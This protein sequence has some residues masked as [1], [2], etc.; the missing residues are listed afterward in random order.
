VDNINLLDALRYGVIGLSAIL[1]ILA[2][3]LLSSEQKR[4]KPREN[5]L[6]SIKLFMLFSALLTLV[7][8][9][10]EAIKPRS[11]T[12]G[13]ESFEAISQKTKLETL[14]VFT[15]GLSKSESSL[16]PIDKLDKIS[17]SQ[18]TFYVYAKIYG[19]DNESHVAQ[20]KLYDGNRDILKSGQK[21]IEKVEGKPRGYYYL[22]L[23]HN[24]KL[25]IERP[26]VWTAEV[27]IDGQLIKSSELE[28]EY[29]SET[30]SNSS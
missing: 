11:S 1:A 29:T 18:K 2:Y 6:S 15:S 14:L 5:I 28:V 17:A 24:P 26:G 20:I 7:G 8:F 4:D 23:E 10:S 16:K 9:G 22:I 3:V 21:T 27:Y 19:L 25:G 30:P 13:V 12:T